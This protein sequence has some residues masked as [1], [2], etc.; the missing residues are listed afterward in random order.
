MSAA[1]AKRAIAN[2]LIA[3][4]QQITSRV[5]RAAEQQL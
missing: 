5:V 3:L 2:C 1:L 4:I